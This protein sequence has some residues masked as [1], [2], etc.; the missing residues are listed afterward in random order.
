[1]GNQI[2]TTE[3]RYTPNP[4]TRRHTLDLDFNIPVI[5]QSQPVSMLDSDEDE[6]VNNILPPTIGEEEINHNPVVTHYNTVLDRKIIT[7]LPI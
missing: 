5:S 1:M 2:H 4:T 3:S 6:S 7:S